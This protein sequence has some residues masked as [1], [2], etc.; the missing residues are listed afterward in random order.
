MNTA[1]LFNQE[2]A[3]LQ[4][5]IEARGGWEKLEREDFLAR[6]KPILE[7]E[8]FPKNAGEHKKP[9]VWTKP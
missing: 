2:A 1:D 5:D 8:P 7:C 3:R 6:W 4:A 9:I